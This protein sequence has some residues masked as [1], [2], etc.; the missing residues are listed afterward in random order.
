MAFP[1][2]GM[3]PDVAVD[4]LCHRDHDN[5]KATCSNEDLVKGTVRSW[6]YQMIL[7]Y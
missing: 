5:A 6:T 1:T 2:P 7:H 4:G 3:K